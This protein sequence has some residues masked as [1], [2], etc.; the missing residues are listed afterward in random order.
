MEH[1][2]SF[3]FNLTKG[4]YYEKN[5]IPGLGHLLG[6]AFFF[7]PGVRMKKTSKETGTQ[8]AS[9]SKTRPQYRRRFGKQGNRADYSAVRPEK[10]GRHPGHLPGLGGYDARP[11]KA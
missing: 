2:F 5:V 9:P 8:K 1:G 4:N 11:A 6:R 7:F 3:S 10:R